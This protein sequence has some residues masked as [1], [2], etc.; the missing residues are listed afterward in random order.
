[1]GLGSGHFGCKWYPDTNRTDG[2]RPPRVEAMYQSA[3]EAN[4]CRCCGNGAQTI[5]QRQ[6]GRQVE[7]SSELLGWKRLLQENRSE[8]GKG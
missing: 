5:Y 7:I 1:M 6:C 8:P 2:V 3:V 4:S